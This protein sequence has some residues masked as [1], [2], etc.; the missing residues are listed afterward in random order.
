MTASTGWLMGLIT[1]AQGTP[2]WESI[3]LEAVTLPVEAGPVSI[4]GQPQPQGSDT[5]SSSTLSTNAK[6]IRKTM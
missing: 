6:D 4:A 2:F 5:H 3:C 1:P